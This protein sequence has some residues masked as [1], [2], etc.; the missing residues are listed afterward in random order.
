MIA[1]ATSLGELADLSGRTAVVTGA[2][3][4]FGA[5]IADRLAEAG[6][7][8][9]V[10]DVR[11]DEAAAAAA[12]IAD[13][14]GATCL[15]SHFD[16][17]DE[18][19]VARAF[20]A[21]GTERGPV[22]ILVNNAGVFSNHLAHEMPMAEFDRILTIN[23]RGAY[24]CSQ[25]ARR[26]MRAAGR[27]AIVTV[28]SVAAYSTSAEGLAHYTTSK[29]AI[30]GMTRSLAVEAAPLGVRVN[31]VCPGAAMTEGAVELIAGGDDTG[32][33]IEAQWDGIVDRTPLGRLCE[34]DDVARAVVFLA[35]DMAAFVTGVLLPVDGG[36]LVQPLEGYVAHGEGA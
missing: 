2:A 23:V 7:T 14:T 4:G 16:V 8:V 26:Q 5:A 24:R 36:I 3:R 34:P 27:G 33:D 13:R 6:A 9:V 18:T 19:A 31:A 29:H 11:T 25:A 1:E 35:S 32:I 30:A 22:D 15:A 12:R 21:W 28:A 10:A 20:A 17:T